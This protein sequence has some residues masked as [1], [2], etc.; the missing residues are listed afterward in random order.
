[1]SSPS[2]PPSAALRDG[3]GA[4]EAVDDRDDGRQETADERA[5]RNGNE[6]LR[7]R[8]GEKKR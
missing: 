1:M 5:D 4:R 8:G 7:A 6:S 3:R 2:E